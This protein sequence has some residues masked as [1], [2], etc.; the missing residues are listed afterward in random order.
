[1]AASI[2]GVDSVRLLTQM[3]KSTLDE[4]IVLL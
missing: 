1:M 4:V 3:L 2:A